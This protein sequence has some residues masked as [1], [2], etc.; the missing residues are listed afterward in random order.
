MYYKSKTS[1][2]QSIV[3]ALISFQSF[4]T[5]SSNFQII[6]VDHT[7]YN[8][9]SLQISIVDIFHQINKLDIEKGTS[10]GT[11]ILLIIRCNHIVSYVSM[12]LILNLLIR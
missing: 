7:P 5:S 4:H 12:M 1:L 6:V 2:D 8:F 3:G 10:S 9:N 11:S